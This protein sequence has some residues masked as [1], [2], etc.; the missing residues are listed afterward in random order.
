MTI[1]HRCASHKVRQHVIH[2][3][4]SG[5]FENRRVTIG[6]TIHRMELGGR[7]TNPFDHKSVYIYTPFRTYVL[8]LFSNLGQQV[9]QQGGQL[10]VIM[11]FLN[12]SEEA[13]E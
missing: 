10:S 9:Y 11:Y 13:S 7:G 12:S 5:L 1:L 2:G 8:F 6:D 3:F 4:G